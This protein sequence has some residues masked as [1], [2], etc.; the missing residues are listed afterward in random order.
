MSFAELYVGEYSRKWY[1]SKG[2]KEAREF[3][4]RG[5]QNNV[6]YAVYARCGTSCSRVQEFDDC[7][8]ALEKGGDLYRVATDPWRIPCAWRGTTQDGVEVV[9]EAVATARP[10]LEDAN[11]W[12]A[13]EPMILTTR[14]SG[15]RL[16]ES[17]VASRVVEVVAPRAQALLEGVRY[18]EL[19]DNCGA[20]FWRDR[21][22][23]APLANLG[24]TAEDGSR[25]TFSAP[26]VEKENELKARKEEQAR[27]DA[28]R[29]EALERELRRA[30]E[31]AAYK[32]ALAE[33]AEQEKQT[34]FDKELLEEEREAKRE[35][36]KFE[37]ETLKAAHELE[38]LKLRQ[39]LELERERPNMERAER[40]RS[41]AQLKEISDGIAG[42]T[43][44]MED[45]CR[46]L[47]DSV[48]TAMERVKEKNTNNPTAP[49]DLLGLYSLEFLAGIGLTRDE[50]YFRRLYGRRFK[51]VAKK[52]LVACEGVCKTRSVVARRET[53]IFRIDQDLKLKFRSPIDGYVTIL[54]LGTQP[55]PDYNLLVPN[56][57]GDDPNGVSPVEAFVKG[58]QRY[59]VPS[60]L[61]YRGDLIEG[62]PVGWEEFVV[63]VTKNEP[64]FADEERFNETSL[65][66]DP[67]PF[68]E[69]GPERLKRVLDD[70]AALDPE[71][72]AVGTCGF[73]VVEAS[74][75]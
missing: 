64:L 46:Q 39:A 33:I 66:R 45:F 12:R 67:N 49:N 14:A 10:R 16:E 13:W 21:I 70:L 7:R 72:Y 5:R 50:K 20:S 61:L 38:M 4:N 71:D 51:D 58:G 26:T 36:L 1:S 47:K 31:D 29:R 48:E 25:A 30:Q 23:E 59:S 44:K 15:G 6:G 53:S 60:D 28:E 35:Q 2:E 34:Q 11:F 74:R 24:L 41:Q 42:L 17:D 65:G 68:T 57:P 75:R 52:V 19:G 40:E 18:A 27:R 37:R 73:T 55:N 22:F 43:G 32:A 3:F 9:V 62:G 69:I 63:I 54:N 56:G 8:K